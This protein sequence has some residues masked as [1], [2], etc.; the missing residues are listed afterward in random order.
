VAG[1]PWTTPHMVHGSIDPV[2]HVF[3]TKI[4]QL[5]QGIPVLRKT[6]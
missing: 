2:H 6:P 5:I 1:P 3:N 4:I